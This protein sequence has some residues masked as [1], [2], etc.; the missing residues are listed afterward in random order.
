MAQHIP[1]L[2]LAQPRPIPFALC[3]KKK[4]DKKG[5]CEDL[6]DAI[7]KNKKTF[8]KLKGKALEEPKKNWVSTAAL[9]AD[10]P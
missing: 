6:T 5:K 8:V 9:L 1:A 3:R 2:S 4:F 10:L 7:M